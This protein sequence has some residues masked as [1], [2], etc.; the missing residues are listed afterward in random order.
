MKEEVPPVKLIPQDILEKVEV[1]VPTPS[2]LAYISGGVATNRQTLL[3]ESSILEGYA[4]VEITFTKLAFIEGGHDFWVVCGID[5][6]F[7]YG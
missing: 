4:Y 2:S 1:G 7:D 6:D 5:R 3:F